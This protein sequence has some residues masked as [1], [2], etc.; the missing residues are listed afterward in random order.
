MIGEA[1]QS[2]EL[3]VVSRR[4]GVGR[5]DSIGQR[6]SANSPRDAVLG[7]APT[8]LWLAVLLTV[9][10]ACSTEENAAE[11]DGA[12]EGLNEQVSLASE[13]TA[14]A[15]RDGV[16]GFAFAVVEPDGI[17][18]A[19]GVGLA[20]VDAALPVTTDTLFHIGST[21]KALDA[22]LVATLVDEGVMD[23]DSSLAESTPGV[24]LDPD[25]TMRHLLTMTSGLPESAEDS[26]P[27]S[28]AEQ[29]RIDDSVFEAFTSAERLGPPGEVFA[30][31][32]VSAAAAGYFAAAA[33]D[34]STENLHQENLDQLAERVLEPLGMT[35][36]VLLAS[37]ARATGDPSRS[38]ELDGEQPIELES[39]DVDLDVLAPSGALKS[40]VSDMGKFLAMLL[41]EGLA[42][43]GTR[44]ISTESIDTMWSPELEG[45]AVG[46]EA[47][48][49]SGVDYVAHEGSWD[50]FLSI[51]MVIPEREVALVLMANS[52]DAAED[53]VSAVPAL[54]VAS[55]E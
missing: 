36:S 13:L 10:A 22:L 17:T 42:P 41:N 44:I 6:H 31:S 32:N 55:T 19:A 51:I 26:V 46:W 30:Y 21:H 20:D 1:V 38:F 12:G 54:F 27:Y 3:K 50:E 24:D 45:Y 40:S 4:E 18:D 39:E 37:Q 53:L 11:S 48:T 16:P 34:P 52:E 7:R 8:G 43:D 29:A 28:V 33:A 15:Q 25:I 23:W 35:D 5:I 9:V 49:E 14:I 2:V 47:G